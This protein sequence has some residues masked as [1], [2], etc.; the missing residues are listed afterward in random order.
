LKNK[1]SKNNDLNPKAI[2]PDVVDVDAYLMYLDVSKKLNDMGDFSI[3]VSDKDLG[4]VKISQPWTRLSKVVSHLPKQ[5]FLKIEALAKTYRSL[6]SKQTAQKNKSFGVKSSGV[7][8]M[9]ETLLDKRRNEII[10][11]F[12][13]FYTVSDVFKIV[14]QKW[15]YNVSKNLVEKFFKDNVDAISDYQEEHKSNLDDVRLFHKK[16][17]LEEL[18]GIYNQAKTKYD[19]TQNREDGKFAAQ[20]L[21]QIQKETE[22]N[23]LII[24]GKMQIDIQATV[25]MQMQLEIQKKTNILDIIVSRAAAR[26]NVNPRYLLSRMHESRYAKLTGMAMLS[27]GESADDNINDIISYPSQFN[28]SLDELKDMFYSNKR[29]EAEEIGYQEVD[30]QSEV[31]KKINDGVEKIK[32]EGI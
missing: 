11:L 32:K 3:E 26:L 30:S 23:R 19:S 17:R 25:S 2:P 14:N 15:G 9:Q 8:S 22:G 12:G 24:D 16:S 10:M 4:K 13:K 18:L 5:E 28:Y 1:S 27:E 29:K 31:A 21:S 20:L 6:K 7:F